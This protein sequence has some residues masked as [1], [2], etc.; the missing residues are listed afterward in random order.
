MA[1]GVCRPG[2][3]TGISGTSKMLKVVVIDNS[4]ISRNLLTSIL[5]NGGHDV[6]GDANTGPASIARMVKLQPQVVCI[7]IG[8]ADGDGMDLIDSVREALPKV[9]LFLVSGT[10]SPDLVQ[11]AIG[12]GVHGF[13]VKPFNAGTVLATIRY[14]I[15]KLARQH[16]VDDAA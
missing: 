10:F 15:I 6:V 2:P 16:K 1:I 14:T 11:A 13:I 8:G 3:S 9:L 5:V 12:H 4:A 7:D